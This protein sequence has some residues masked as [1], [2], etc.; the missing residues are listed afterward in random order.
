M[1]T[2][3]WLQ[4]RQLEK[5][6]TDT[7]CWLYTDHRYQWLDHIPETVSTHPMYTNYWVCC[8]GHEYDFLKTVTNSALRPVNDF[9][10]I[11]YKFLAVC[12]PWVSLAKQSMENNDLLLSLDMSDLLY[13]DHGYHR[14]PENRA[15]RPVTDYTANG[16]RW[17]AL[18]WHG[19]DWLSENYPGY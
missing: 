2:S 3:D 9:T 5:Q 8:T 13:T 17:F 7:S 14:L 1:D 16:Y 4:Y 6:T 10:T 12:I 15:R 19:Y 18:Y 11:G